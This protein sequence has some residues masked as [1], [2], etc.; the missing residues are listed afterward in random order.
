MEEDADN[1]ESSS[2]VIHDR[3]V[4]NSPLEPYTPTTA[5]LYN[6]VGE[7]SV[8]LSTAKVKVQNAAGVWVSMIAI[9]DSGSQQSLCSFQAANVLGLK[10]Q[11]FCATI[12]EA[13]GIKEES[14]CDPDDQAMQH[15][16]SSVRFNSGRYEVGFPW[17]RDKQELNDNFSL[18]ENR[19]K[20]L[21]KRFIRDPTLFKQYFEILK[22]YE[23]Q[24]IIER[25]FQT[26]RPTNRAVLYLPHQAILRQESLTTKMRIVFDAS[27]HED[28]QLALNECICQIGCLLGG[29][30]L[31]AR[32]AKEVKKTI[33]QK[34][35]TKAFL[36]TDSQI[37]L[38]W[39]KSPS[40]IWKPF[41]ANRVR[42]I[43]ALTDPNSWFHCSGKDNPADLLTRGISVDALS[44]N[45]KWWNGS[46]FLRV[47]D[48]LT[49]GINEPIPERLY[50]TEMKKNSH[51]SKKGHF[52]D[53]DSD[54]KQFL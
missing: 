12:A 6:E 37:T 36:W 15:F 27:S 49:K 16:K 53:I 18:A 51:K 8:L 52:L 13:I 2:G 33:D 26:E 7:R 14:S 21:A 44:T 1:L 48:F 54:S 39:I 50:L 28:G 20:S 29:A 22:E 23:S 45:S 24:G 31:A 34:C 32:L 41:V 4:A 43:Q 10:K 47:T 17:K 42:E 5:C 3:S 38:C 30:L 11:D 19:A 40:H 35:S 46:S 9:L 25:V